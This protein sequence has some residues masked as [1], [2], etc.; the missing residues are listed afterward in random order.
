MEEFVTVCPRNCYITCSFCV[1][2][3]NNKIRRIL[4]YSDNLATPE[5]PCIKGL[6]YPERTYTSERIIYPLLKT[7]NGTFQQIS[8]DEAL[9]VISKNLQL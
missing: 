8:I 5:R 4:P 2:V 7:T 6:S 9:D 1:Q 3:E